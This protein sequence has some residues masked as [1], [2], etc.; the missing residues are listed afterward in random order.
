MAEQ[1]RR[2]G[3]DLVEVGRIATV[4][5]I[6]GELVVDPSTENPERFAPGTTLL[7][8]RPDG[9]VSPCTVLGAR[10]HRGRL[11]VRLDGVDDR[12]AAERLRGGRL[13]IREADLPPLPPGRLWRHELPGMRVETPAGEPLGTVRELLDTGA[14]SPLLVVRGVRGEVLVPFVEPFVERVDPA[15]GL[16][17]V[18]LPEGLAPE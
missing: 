11:L 2:G 7:L 1:P 9:V 15:A 18:T 5:G 12:S 8:E 4:H 16:I 14:E 17:V 6:R 3:D 13:C 10:P